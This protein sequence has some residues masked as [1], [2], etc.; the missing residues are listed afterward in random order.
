[1]SDATERDRAR[2]ILN[3]RFRTRMDGFGT[4]P[5][6]I[7]EIVNELFPEHAVDCM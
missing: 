3:R 7:D 4:H 6:Y 2:E 1:M 5:D